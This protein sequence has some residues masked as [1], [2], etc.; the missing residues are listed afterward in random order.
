[1]YK[2]TYQILELNKL[3]PYE[4]NN[5][6]HKDKNISEIV[7]SIQANT[8]VNPIIVDENYIILAGHGRKLALDKM[9]VKEAEVLIVE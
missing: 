4:K 5:K 8:Y 1:M 2:R 7:K 9:Q 3:I 6:I